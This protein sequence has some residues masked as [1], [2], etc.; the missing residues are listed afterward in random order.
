M[1]DL[2]DAKDKHGLLPK[3]EP[4]MFA[5]LKSLEEWCEVAKLAVNT[6]QEAKCN[7]N[8]AKGFKLEYFYF[9][10][11]T[12]LFPAGTKRFDVMKF[13]HVCGKTNIEEASDYSYVK[14]FN[15]YINTGHLNYVVIESRLGCPL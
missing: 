13:M 10:F 12:M 1:G 9:T 8:C 4:K 11:A 2:S 5:H 6:C 3:T 14:L 7:S 15:K